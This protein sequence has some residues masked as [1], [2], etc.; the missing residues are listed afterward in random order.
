MLGLAVA[1]A[2][3]VGGCRG[4]TPSP[5]PTKQDRA[6]EALTSD[7]P[8]PAIPKFDVAPPGPTKRPNRSD[9]PKGFVVLDAIETTIRIDMR[10][11]TADNFTGA[12]LPGYLPGSAWL[13]EDAADALAKVQHDLA[14]EGL[15]LL[16]FD[17][18]RPA[19]ATKAM[20]AWAEATKHTQLL[21]DGYIARVSNH[22]R[23][24]TL[25]LTLV[26]LGSGKELDMGTPWDTFS[27]ASHYASATGKPMSNRKR[28]RVAMKKRGFVP[29]DKEWWHFSLRVETD[30]PT[31]DVPYGT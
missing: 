12:P 15:G 24:H 28:L 26:S 7:L 21:S 14:S 18:Y 20:V 29:Y 1:V 25:D 5:T 3:G 22:N 19:R 11:A 13:T 10:Y 17:A 8:N 9:P 31:L 27:E 4:P 6:V 30:P 23:G 16:V 2:A